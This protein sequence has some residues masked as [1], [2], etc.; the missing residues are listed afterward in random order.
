MNGR[1]SVPAKRKMKREI[2]GT[3]AGFPVLMRKQKPAARR[4]QAMLGN[5]KRSRLRRPKV[6]IV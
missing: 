5:V 1:K 4:V 6:S 2:R 3:L